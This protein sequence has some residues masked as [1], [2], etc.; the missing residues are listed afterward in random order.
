MI[1]GASGSGKSR[2]FIKPFILKT[3]KLMQSMIIVDPK[4]EMAEQMAEYLKKKK[5]ML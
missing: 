3:A 4:A 5:A 2:G 1:Y